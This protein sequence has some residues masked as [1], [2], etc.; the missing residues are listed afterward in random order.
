MSHS[1]SINEVGKLFQARMVDAKKLNL[2][3][4]E[5]AC[6]MIYHMYIGNRL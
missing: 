6:G 5:L 3:E 2:Y 4:S 1:V